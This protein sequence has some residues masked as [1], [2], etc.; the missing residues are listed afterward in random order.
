M[1]S[2]AASYKYQIAIGG[3]LLL[4]GAAFSF[5]YTINI[6]YNGLETQGTVVGY[7]VSQSSNSD[8]G[9]PTQMY[10][11]QVNFKTLDGKT[12]AFSSLASSNT[13]D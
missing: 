7:K 3:L 11:P 13:R 5:I 12:I 1:S 2:A 8:G 10:A 6:L 9:R 4:I